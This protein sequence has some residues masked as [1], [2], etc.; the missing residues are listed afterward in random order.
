MGRKICGDTHVCTDELLAD[1]AE[2]R[3]GEERGAELVP[4]DHV[5]FGLFDGAAP[6]VQSGQTGPLGLGLP[7]P[8]GP[9]PVGPAPGRVA[10]A[11][12]GTVASDRSSAVR[13]FTMTCMT[14]PRC[15][16]AS[17]V[18]LQGGYMG[19]STSSW[20]SRPGSIWNRENPIRRNGDMAPG[21][22]GTVKTEEHKIRLLK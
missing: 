14:R 22:R 7:V 19:L 21:P 18:V 12:R 9:V 6:R 20:Y 13:S 10:S 17:K 2:C 11:S 8:V 1:G 4:F 3:L 15:T 5:D 16:W